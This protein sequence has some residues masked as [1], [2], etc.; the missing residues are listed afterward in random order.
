[1]DVYPINLADELPQGVEFRF[2]LAPVVIRRPIAR[3][4]CIVS[5]CTPCD[6][7]VTNSRSDHLVALMRLRRSPSASSEKWTLKGRMAPEFSF[8]AVSDLS[9]ATK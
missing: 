6:V 3:D 1:M 7:S 9:A 5:I 8:E 4:F 2:D